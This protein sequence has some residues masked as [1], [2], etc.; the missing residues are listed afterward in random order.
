MRNKDEHHPQVRHRSPQE[1]RFELRQPTP[2]G[3]L[4]GERI[5]EDLVAFGKAGG[6]IEVLGNT[7]LR[8][9]AQAVKPAPTDRG[10]KAVPAT[11]DTPPEKA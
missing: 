6:K 4:T 2:A 7:P 10:G 9:K 8:G 5:A 11:A 1:N 3:P